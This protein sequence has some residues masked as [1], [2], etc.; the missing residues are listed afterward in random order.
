MNIELDKNLV[1]TCNSRSMFNAGTAIVEEANEIY[2]NFLKTFNDE[3]Y[4]SKQKE[5]IEKRTKVFK[6][7][8]TQSY[9]EYLN[10]SQNYVSWAVA[11][12]A[13]YNKTRYQKILGRMDKKHSEISDKI[14]K[15]FDNT[16]KMLKNDL[17]KDEVLT[18]YRNGYDEPISSDDPLAKEKLKAKLEYLE[19]KHQKYKDFNKDARKNG[20]DQLP[21]YVLANSNQNIKSVKDR[22]STLEKMNQLESGGYYFNAGEVRFDKNDMRVKIFFDERPDENVR[23]NLKEH[24]FK[25]SPSNMAWQR[26]LTPNAIYMTKQM[27][28]DIGSLEIKLVEDYTKKM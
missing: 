28:K 26:K 10:I 11:G 27:F 3:N 16:K 8:L 7:F 13:N 2:D 15:F 18:K 9:N 12:P 24:G 1:E 14:D 22:L 25:W 21:S 20:T 4:N 6:E 17:S 23:Q 5:T 19:T